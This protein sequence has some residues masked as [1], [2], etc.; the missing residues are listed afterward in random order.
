M[1]LV[2]REGLGNKNAV[3][4]TRVRNPLWF[5]AGVRSVAGMFSIVNRKTSVAGQSLISNFTFN[6]EGVLS[7]ILSVEKEML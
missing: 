3:L 4:G 6:S 2:E 5:D 7:V 1:K